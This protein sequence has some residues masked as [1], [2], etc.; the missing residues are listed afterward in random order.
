MTEE[1]PPLPTLDDVL[2]RRSQPP[3]CL[4]NYYI[5]LRDRLHLE[6]LL[7]FWLDVAQAD[8]LYKRYLK[9]ATR[10]PTPHHQTH[11]TLPI[12]PSNISSSILSHDDLF[13]HMLLTHPRNSLATTIASTKKPPPT[14]AQ[15]TD[16]VERIYLRYIV[17]NAEKELPLPHRIKE[18]IAKHF[19]GSE[20]PKSTALFGEAKQYVRDE[21]QRTFG[22]FLRYKVCMNV[23]WPQQVGRLAAG[24]IALLVGFSYEF[25]MVFL[26]VRPWQTRLWVRDHSN[27]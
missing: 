26:D 13:T 24:L 12:R 4:F 2:H 15:M 20:K 19:V 9:Y 6:P 14:I 25:S 1:K 7:D 22:L 18:E 16:T 3:V 17:S 23:T 8:I 10:P 21:L 27:L 11:A 5:V